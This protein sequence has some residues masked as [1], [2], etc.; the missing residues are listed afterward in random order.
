[1]AITV[2]GCLAQKYNKW[3]AVISLYDEKG[4][5]KQKWI[6]TGYPIKG[7]KKK[8]EKILKEKVQEYESKRISY[9]TDITVAE[10]FRMWLKEIVTEVRPNTY[11]V[12]KSNME[13]HIIPYFENDGIR[14]Q[15][16]ETVDL[17]EYYKFIQNNTDLSGQTIKHHHQNISKALNDAIPKY[18]SFNPANKQASKVIKEKRFKAE[19]LND[20]QIDVLLELV[21][22]LPIRLAVELCCIY[23]FRRSEVLGLKWHNVD[24]NN[25]SIR[26]CETLQ[27]S[28]KALTGTTNYT[29]DTKTDSS[30]RTMPMTKK[31]K[32]LL[33]EQRERQEYYRELLGDGYI[34]TDYVCT[35]DN[36][37]VITPNYLSKNFHKVIESS[38]LPHVRLHDLRHSSVSN[39]LSMGFTSVQVSEWHGHSSPVTT[40]KYY[41]H[42]D[43]TSKMAI[44]NALDSA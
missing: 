17:I 40:M 29:D 42:A 36:G 35:F 7:N 22:D 38:N 20:N 11:R 16:L 37:K 18:L 44:A 39:K 12:Y 27:Q 25:K 33:Q 43:K 23:G 13:N 14:L 24:F 2:T 5:R 15:D 30:T 1:M 31:A 41:A 21:Q 32:K 26:I 10:Y 4:K 3:Y 9:Y 6:P 34:E 8:A 19:F 28:T